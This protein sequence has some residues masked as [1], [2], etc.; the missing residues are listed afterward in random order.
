MKGQ[1]RTGPI[2][3][4]VLAG[5]NGQLEAI[6][7]ECAGIETPAAIR[8][9]SGRSGV[10]TDDHIASLH[11]GHVS[12]QIHLAD[13]LVGATAARLPANRDVRF[14]RATCLAGDDDGTIHRVLERTDADA[15]G[16]ANI[17]VV[18]IDDIRTGPQ[19]QSATVPPLLFWVPM[20]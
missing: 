12:S 6:G 7:R 5:V 1:Q 2:A 18:D 13:V 20:R 11:R 9:A 3:G 15:L 19:R 16:E 10:G 17:D 14:A 8:A 4:P